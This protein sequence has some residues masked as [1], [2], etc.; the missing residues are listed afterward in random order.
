MASTDPDW[1]TCIGPG[2]KPLVDPLIAQCKEEG[3]PILQV[4]EKFGGLRFYTGGGSA[5]LVTM[6]ATAEALSVRTCEECGK[7][8]RTVAPHGWVRTLC[9]E[10]S[11]TPAP[12]KRIDIDEPGPTVTLPFAT[13]TEILL[14]LDRARAF[15]NTR[16][17]MPVSE[18]AAWDDLRARLAAH[19]ITPK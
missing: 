15:L 16:K 8:G 1:T 7:P 3:T 5:K 13:M 2:W 4:K 6:I 18:I 19:R 10:H 12:V 9:Y 14:A 11:Q 17:V